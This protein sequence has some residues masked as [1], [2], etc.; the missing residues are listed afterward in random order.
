MN[1]IRV[2]VVDDSALVRKVLSAGLSSAKDIEVVGTAVDPYDA[3]DKIISLNPDVL[4][5]D[6]HM[7]R[8]DGLSFLAKLMK[9]KPMPVVVVSSVAKHDTETGLRALELGAVEVVGK[10]G[11]EFSTPDDVK[12]NLTRAVR[13]AA[14]AQIGG[15]G[16]AA[17]T[18]I[19]RTDSPY[20]FKH[21]DHVLAI[22]ASTGGTRA[23][24]A[25]LERLPGNLPG[26]VIVQHM[27][28]NFTKGFADTLDRYCSLEVKEAVDWD[29]VVPG[30]ALVAPGGLH[31]I[32]KQSSQKT[33]VRLKNGPQVH[34]QRPA[35]D[36]LFQ[37]VAKAL[38]NKATGVVLTGMGADGAAGLLALKEAGAHTICQDEASSVVFGMPKEAINCGAAQEVRPL[39][40]IHLSII[41]SLGGRSIKVGV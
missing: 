37:S 29:E 33:Y 17:K 28:A 25:V 8:M 12:R 19:S 11:S 36:I 10:S 34:F 14:K 2:L 23:I 38:G 40:D 35:V 1:V 20:V 18:A 7:P 21:K 4:T 26:V 16:A 30:V 27:P 3:R 32:V 9:F 13:A 22:G 24:Q 39:N 15:A 6:I 31:M 5:L 41:K